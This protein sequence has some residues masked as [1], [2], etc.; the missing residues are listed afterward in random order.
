MLESVD[1]YRYQVFI[2]SDTSAAGAALMERLL[3][4][5]IGDHYDLRLAVETEL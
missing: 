1:L 4:E 3:P 5:L 2:L